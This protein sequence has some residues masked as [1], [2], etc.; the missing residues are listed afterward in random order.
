MATMT[1]EGH[2]YPNVSAGDIS[3]KVMHEFKKAA[4]EHFN[5]K[6]IA[7]DAQV[8]K[9][10]DCFNDHQIS[11]WVEVEHGHLTAM[12][13]PI[14]MLEFHQ[15]YLQPLWEEKTHVK[16]LTLSQ[17]DNS[18]WEFAVTVQKTNSLMRHTPSHK[19][20]DTI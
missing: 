10:L 3:V 7:A 17:G 11:D 20:P 19:D 9:I 5:Q 2:K 16:F 18:F 12:T 8:A 6:D 4:H 13:F 15:L 14:F 1:Q